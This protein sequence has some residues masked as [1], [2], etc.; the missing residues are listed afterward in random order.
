MDNIFSLTREKLRRS[1][2]TYTIAFH[3]SEDGMSFVVHDIQD[4][5]K[6]RLAVARD[7]EAAAE[8]LRAET[9]SEG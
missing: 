7:L 9:N 2:V 3:H 8:S 5:K 4:T 1:P 6:D